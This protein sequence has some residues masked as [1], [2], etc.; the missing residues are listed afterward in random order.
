MERAVIKEFYGMGSD[1]LGRPAP[2]R[3]HIAPAGDGRPM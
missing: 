2:V 3:I 1:D